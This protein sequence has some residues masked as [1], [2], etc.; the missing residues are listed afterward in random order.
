MADRKG[1]RTWNKP[2]NGS[3]DG[4]KP[5]YTHEDFRN[6]LEPNV[7]LDGEI[8]SAKKN[9]LLI[10]V[11]NMRTVDTVTDSPEGVLQIIRYDIDDNVK[12]KHL[13]SILSIFARKI[14]KIFSRQIEMFVVISVSDQRIFTRKIRKIFSRQI[15]MFVLI[16][17][18]NRWIFTKKTNP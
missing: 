17:V 13:N 14:R 6:A 16:F 10:E 4:G 9:F 11:Q 18:S 5:R 2:N 3:R 7:D 15:E 12:V 8:R 1:G